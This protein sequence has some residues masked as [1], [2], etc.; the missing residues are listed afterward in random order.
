MK[1]N[2]AFYFIREGTDA[3]N[4]GVNSIMLG[5]AVEKIS[6]LTG[7]TADQIYDHLGSTVT[8]LNKQSPDKVDQLG[9]KMLKIH[10]KEGNG[11]A[12]A[13]IQLG[14]RS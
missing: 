11:L 9:S 10:A 13:Q 5:L 7:E 4:V 8:S 12:I 14:I 1:I 6:E 3:K 2:P